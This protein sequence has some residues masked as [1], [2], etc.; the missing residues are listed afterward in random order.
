MKFH[1]PM[2]YLQVRHNGN[3]P[4]DQL[5]T[6]LISATKPKT[7]GEWPSAV[8]R[9][10]IVIAKDGDTAI[11]NFLKNILA[12]AEEIKK[13]L[14]PEDMLPIKTMAYDEGKLQK[15]KLYHAEVVT[16]QDK[17]TE[18]EDRTDDL[19]EVQKEGLIENIAVNNQ[20]I[21]QLRRQEEVIVPS[22]FER[23]MKRVSELPSYT[24][25]AERL[26]PQR[27]YGVAYFD[28]SRDYVDSSS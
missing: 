10:F 28:D 11:A 2:G 26:D 9:T 20:R 14:K 24:L 13:T 16:M 3:A 27:C 25:T 7:D 22:K 4:E 18:L 12:L 21:S 23:I 19:A 8:C 6:F 17:L 1:V 5:H 15:A